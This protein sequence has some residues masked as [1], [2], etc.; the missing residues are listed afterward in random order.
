MQVVLI[1][2]SVQQGEWIGADVGRL[3]IQTGEKKEKKFSLDGVA[4]LIFSTECESNA[5]LMNVHLKD[6]GQLAGQIVDGGADAVSLQTSLGRLEMKFAALAALR[7]ADPAEF[8]KAHEVFESAL[9]ARLPGHDVLITREKDEVKT[10]RGALQELNSERGIFSFADRARTFQLDKIYGVVLAAGAEQPTSFPMTVE[11]KDGGKFSGQLVSGDSATI[12]L[13]ASFGHA[14]ALP[15]DK[16]C[17]IE[18]RSDRITYVSDLTPTS[19]KIDGVIHEA[20]KPRRDRSAANTPL[21]MDGRIY[22]KGI[23]VHS[24]SE[25][26][27]DLAGKYAEFVATI[28]IDDYVRPRGAVI[29]RVM[30]DGKQIFESGTMTGKDAPRNISVPVAGVR[31][32]TLVV[33]YGEGLDIAD[34]ADWGGARL[35]KPETPSKGNKP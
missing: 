7:I 13:N 23:G 24:K 26:T 10:V 9:G 16:I 20:W 1:D 11:M 22:R 32:L 30:G 25:L 3:V 12:N 15:V 35:I 4:S 18:T 14:V 19:E 31:A 6:G 29:F 8:P 27:Y 34:H 28:G 17:R 5:G 33:D 2:D 21:S